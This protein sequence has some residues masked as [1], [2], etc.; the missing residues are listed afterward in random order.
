MFKV[1]DSLGLPARP[2]G[3][4]QGCHCMRI[5]LLQPT[6]QRVDFYVRSSE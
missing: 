5:S 4:C 2:D 3:R 6:S 1:L